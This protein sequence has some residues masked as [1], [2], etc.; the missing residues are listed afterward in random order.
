MDWERKGDCNGCGWCCEKIARDV[1][2][3]TDA[4]VARD[5]A[6]YAAR[7]FQP[8]TVDGERRHVLWAWLEAPCPELRRPVHM[9]GY[10]VV[11]THRCAIHDSKPET[12]RTFP[13]LPQDVVGTPCSYWFERTEDDVAGRVTRAGGT[14]SPHAMTPERLRETEGG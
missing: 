14:G 4:Q 2:V 1:L 10:G 3:R 12:C 6:Y 5:P 8:V 7:G 9:P 11:G 13:R